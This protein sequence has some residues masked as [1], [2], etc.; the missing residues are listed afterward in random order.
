MLKINNNPALFLGENKYG[1]DFAFHSYECQ[2]AQLIFYFVHT[3]KSFIF[4]G[5]KFRGFE[6]NNEFVDIYFRCFFM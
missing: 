1:L 6:F 2:V 4:M 5:L 3:V